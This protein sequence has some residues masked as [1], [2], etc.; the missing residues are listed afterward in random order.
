MTSSG[1]GTLHMYANRLVRTPD[2]LF[3]CSTASLG[4]RPTCHQSAANRYLATNRARTRSFEPAY[5]SQS[6]NK[7]LRTEQQPRIINNASQASHACRASPY[8][9]NIKL[10]KYSQDEMFSPVNTVRVNQ[11][12]LTYRASIIACI[13]LEQITEKVWA[14]LR[15][16][17]T[18]SHGTTNT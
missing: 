15:H 7:R 3:R 14:H 1:A 6:D 12:S 8:L 18:L 2:K 9:I 11:A 4:Y 13:T 5:R 10:I 16:E 17:H